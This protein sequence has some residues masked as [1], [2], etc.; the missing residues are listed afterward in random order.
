MFPGVLGMD[1]AR[2]MSRA[3]T[4][5]GCDRLIVDLREHWRRHRLPAAHEPAVRRPPRRGLQRRPRSRA[6]GYRK[7]HL[8]AFDRIPSSKLGVVPLMLR[9]ATAGR[10]V[11]VFTENLGSRPFTAVWR[12]WSTNTLRALPKWSLGLRPNM[13]SPPSWARTP[14]GWS[15]LVLKRLV[16][17]TASLS[18]SGRTTRGREPLS[19]VVA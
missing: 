13:G 3:V 19:K 9:F 15:P 8:P 4:E 5:L 18:R 12:C 7:E 11:A 14:V 2:D 1:V 17:A 6:K 10:S 16:A